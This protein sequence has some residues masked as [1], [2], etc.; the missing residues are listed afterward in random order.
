MASLL[1]Q[2]QAELGSTEENFKARPHQQQS[3]SN[4]IKATG[5]FVAFRQVKCYKVVWSFDNVV[6]VSSR[7]SNTV[8]LMLKAVFDL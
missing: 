4:I 3:G 5:N 7:T 8:T 1:E 6:A 2:L